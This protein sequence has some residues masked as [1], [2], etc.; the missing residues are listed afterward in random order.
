MEWSGVDD[1][2][3]KWVVRKRGD[4]TYGLVKERRRERGGLKR[5]KRK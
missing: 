2:R 1:G 4:C 3:G 5:E